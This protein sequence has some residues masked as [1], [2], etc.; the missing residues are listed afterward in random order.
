MRINQIEKILKTIPDEQ[1]RQAILNELVGERLPTGLTKA[2]VDDIQEIINKL[3][4]YAVYYSKISDT[5]D[6]VEYDKLKKEVIPYLQSLATY[7]ALLQSEYDYLDDLVRKERRIQLVEKIKDEEGVSFTQ[8]DKLVEADARYAML[9]KQLKAIRDI[10]YKVKTMYDFHL[11]VW[12][13]IFQSVSTAT[14]ELHQNR[15]Q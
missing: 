13:K 7:K 10:Y 6:I 1:D 3:N 2:M 15:M 12:E 9:K 8:A 11:K 4:Q 14:K 5:G